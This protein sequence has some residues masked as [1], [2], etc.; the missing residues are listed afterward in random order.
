LTG[1]GVS[2]DGAVFAGFIA[3]FGL[4]ATALYWR[5]SLP[6]Y[7]ARGGVDEPY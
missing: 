2:A 4:R 1:V 5:L 7:R 3:A 6:R